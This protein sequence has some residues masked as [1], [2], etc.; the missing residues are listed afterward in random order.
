MYVVDSC[1]ADDSRLYNVW[2]VTVRSPTDLGLSRGSFFFAVAIRRGELRSPAGR[3]GRR[4][5]RGGVCSFK[6]ILVFVGEAFCLPFLW[7][8]R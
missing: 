4:P 3:R 2:Y 8:K 6:I 5:L 1:M 7:R